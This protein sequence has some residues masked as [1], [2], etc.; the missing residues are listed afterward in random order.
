[1]VWN[2]RP[3]TDESGR[4][5]KAGHRFMNRSYGVTTPALSK[6]CCDGGILGPSPMSGRTRKRRSPLYEPPVMELRVN[7][8]L[9]CLSPVVMVESSPSPMSGRTLRKRGHRFTEPPAMEATTCVV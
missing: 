9:R 7:P 5:A 4:P 8:I 2:L 1:M 6:P 3:I